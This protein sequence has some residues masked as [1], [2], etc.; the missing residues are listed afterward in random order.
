MEVCFF[1][2]ISHL[3]KK[4]NLF[5]VESCGYG[6]ILFLSGFLPFQ[7]LFE[8][9]SKLRHRYEEKILREK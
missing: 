5:K 9:D 1:M 4:I 7:F 8:S 2:Y 6:G 3:Q